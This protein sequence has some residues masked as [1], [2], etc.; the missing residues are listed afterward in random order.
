MSR[1]LPTLQDAR[2]ALALADSAANAPW[3]DGV[4]VEVDADYLRAALDAVDELTRERDSLRNELR[5]V[6]GACVV[7]ATTQVA[8]ADDMATYVRACMDAVAADHAANV[9]GL[10]AAVDHAADRIGEVVA[11]RDEIRAAER[12]AV[13]AYL[14]TDAANALN[15][16]DVADDIAANRHYYPE[17]PQ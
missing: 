11:E 9:R 2:D 13:V 12:A 8:Y 16:L 17:K 10:E 1:E 4:S 7:P 3:A 6:L 14:R 15:I 5:N